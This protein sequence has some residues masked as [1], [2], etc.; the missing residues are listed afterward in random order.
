MNRNKPKISLEG[1]NVFNG[2]LKQGI[3][4]IAFCTGNAVFTDE[5]NIMV[6][7]CDRVAIG[8]FE[9]FGRRPDAADRAASYEWAFSNFVAELV[10]GHLASC[11]EQYY[12]ELEIT[13]R[14]M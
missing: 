5:E 7:V 2:S 1:I 4:R 10:F 6:I 3:K 14:Y 12:E 11:I 8:C 13:S 9:I